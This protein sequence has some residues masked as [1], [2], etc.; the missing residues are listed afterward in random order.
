MN[1]ERITS[2]I[3]VKDLTYAGH[4]NVASSCMLHLQTQGCGAVRILPLFT[5]FATSPPMYSFLLQ[6]CHMGLPPSSPE[7]TY[8]Q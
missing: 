7:L 4:S 1:D 3:L 5:P 8:P 6:R 2:Q